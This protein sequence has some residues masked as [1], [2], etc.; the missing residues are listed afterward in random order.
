MYVLDGDKFRIIGR[1]SE[2][3]TYDRNGRCEYPSDCGYISKCLE[4]NNGNS[5]YVKEKL[6]KE[7]NQYIRTVS[8]DTG[9]KE[10]DIKNLSMKSRTYFTRVIKDRSNKNVGILVIESTNATLPINADE[11]NK[12]LEE[13]SIPHMSTFLDVSNKLKGGSSNE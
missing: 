4:N 7:T 3:P 5:Y 11:L 10:D 2:N 6:P 9:M 8:K 12:K 1:Y 13:L